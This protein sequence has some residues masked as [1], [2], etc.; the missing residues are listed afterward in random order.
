MCTDTPI[1]LVV[2][3]CLY[4]VVSVIIVACS[5]CV[6]LSVYVCVG[7]LFAICVCD[8]TIFSLRVIVL[9]L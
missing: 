7:E 4:V 6:F 3:L 8:V 9:L 2:I 5:L 1:S